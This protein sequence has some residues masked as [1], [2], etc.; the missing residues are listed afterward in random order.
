MDEIQ[1]LRKIEDLKRQN[2]KILGLAVLLIVVALSTA[3][4]RLDLNHR[5]PG[6]VKGKEFLLL[7][8]SG[9]TVGRWR[10]EG[11]GACLDLVG[12]NKSAVIAICASDDFGS[13]VSASSRN[14]ELH[15]ILSAGTKPTESP[16]GTFPPGLL[17]SDDNGQRLLQVEVASESRLIFGNNSGK[18][19]ITVDIPEGGKP[20][21]TV[22]GGH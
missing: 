21:I 7:S 9:E 17:I 18:N 3:V 8:D 1:L 11:T 6:Q 2:Y 10:N 16:Q 15:A 22:S 13:Y 14:G 4:W 12:R 20:V 19:A 5:V